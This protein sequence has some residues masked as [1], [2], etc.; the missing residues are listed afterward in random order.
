MPCCAQCSGSCILACIW[1]VLV[2]LFDGARA[3]P[4][5]MPS[6]VSSENED[7]MQML[8]LLLF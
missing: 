5:T 6:L 4:E 2:L 3:S 1:L 8:K 7:N